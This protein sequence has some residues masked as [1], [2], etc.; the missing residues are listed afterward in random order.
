[1]PCVYSY[2]MFG[3]LKKFF[4]PK[5][6]ITYADV[7]G[8]EPTYNSMS[9][10]GAMAQPAVYA[11]VNLLS[12]VIAA[13]PIGIKDIVTG[14]KVY[15]SSLYKLLAVSPNKF[16]T[17]YEWRN[18]TITSLLLAGVG[19]ARLYRNNAGE[20]IS[21]IPLHPDSVLAT[22]VPEKQDI[23]YDITYYSTKTQNGTTNK[24][25]QTESVWSE[26]MLVDRKSTRLNSSH[27]L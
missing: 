21:L 13:M 24:Y 27:R 7:Y 18:M 1:M 4:S 14:K 6:V 10:T 12:T 22:F 3:A 19:Y 25:Y 26:N 15:D 8:H 17:S 23:R 2:L 16:L 9:S 20:V 11:C 5:N